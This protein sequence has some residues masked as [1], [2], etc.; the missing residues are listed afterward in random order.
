MPYI[1]IW[2]AP[3]LNAFNRMSPKTH[4]EKIDTI[5]QLTASYVSEAKYYKLTEVDVAPVVQ[6]V[7]DLKNSV[8]AGDGGL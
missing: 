6:A 7:R 1:K 2:N 4:Y 5:E 8:L 3:A